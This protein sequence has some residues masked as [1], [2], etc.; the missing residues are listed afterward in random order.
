MKKRG[1]LRRENSMGQVEVLRLLEKHPRLATREI[2]EV[3]NLRIRQVSFL[4]YRLVKSK[5]VVAV[6]PT[7]EELKRIL[8]KF[9]KSVHCLWQLKVFKVNDE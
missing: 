7:G 2:A 6:K 4:L 8:I 3:L 9:P 1:E 5:E